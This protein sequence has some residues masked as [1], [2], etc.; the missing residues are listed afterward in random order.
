MVLELGDVAGGAMALPNWRHLRFGPEL[1]CLD[2]FD[3]YEEDVK[4]GGTRPAL[5]ASVP[6]C[7]G[8]TWVG[9]STARVGHPDASRLF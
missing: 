9:R 7:M 6:A 3:S 8:G 5:H 1:Y 2:A 4:V